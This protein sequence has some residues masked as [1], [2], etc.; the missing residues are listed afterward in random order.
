[1]GFTISAVGAWLAYDV[2]SEYGIRFITFAKYAG[3]VT[4]LAAVLVWLAAFRRPQAAPKQWLL[5]VTPEQM[6]MQAKQ[7]LALLKGNK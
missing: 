2:R 4:Y 5:G 7:Y 1:L 6:L 3:P